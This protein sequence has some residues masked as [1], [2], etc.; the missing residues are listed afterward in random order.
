L[1]TSLFGFYY[2][3]THTSSTNLTVSIF[4]FSS[5]KWNALHTKTYEGSGIH[6][7]DD[8]SSVQNASAYLGKLG[9]NKFSWRVRI[10]LE[11][12]SSLSI[13]SSYLDY[14][15]N[16]SYFCLPIDFPSFQN[17]SQNCPQ[18]PED[19]PRGVP[20]FEAIEIST[21]SPIE[22]KTNFKVF[23]YRASGESDDPAFK[24]YKGGGKFEIPYNNSRGT[25]FRNETYWVKQPDGSFRYK[26][27]IM[28]PT[29]EAFIMIV[30]E[31]PELENTQLADSQIQTVLLID[32][33][34]LYEF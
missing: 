20:I 9:D 22:Y 19:W 8:T 33:I 18:D 2:N 13:E 16:Q 11:G 14:V 15:L 12:E 23:C 24:V 34:D 10:R 25:F 6:Q 31:D 7:F 1:D 4:N 30:W 17:Y 3:L 26:E 28:P 32:T 5:A 27:D 29:D 21:D